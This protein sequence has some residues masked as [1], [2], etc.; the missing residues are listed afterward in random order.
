MKRRSLKGRDKAD[1]SFLHTRQRMQERHGI[2]MSREDYNRL[3]SDIVI[4]EEIG[5]EEMAGTVQRIFMLDFRGFKKFVWDDKRGCVT[6][7]LG[8]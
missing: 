6:T 3:N 1:Y 2:N 4:G 7:V 8:R 5:I